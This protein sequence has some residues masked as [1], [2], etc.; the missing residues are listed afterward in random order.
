MYVYPPDCAKWMDRIGVRLFKDRTPA[1]F[2]LTKWAWWALWGTIKLD[3]GLALNLASN[4]HP[5]R[6]H[7]TLIL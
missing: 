7:E 2:G 4:G 6:T 3:G 5:Y 1:E